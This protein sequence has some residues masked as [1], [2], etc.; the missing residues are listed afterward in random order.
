LASSNEQLA[1]TPP[2][3]PF[4]P[5]SSP[6]ENMD[7]SRSDSPILTENTLSR[8]VELEAKLASQEAKNTQVLDALNTMLRLLTAMTLTQP[9]TLPSTWL[10]VS[11]AT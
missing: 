10:L 5:I 9:T 3:F 6:F 1:V 2:E 8:L 7:L 11:S 4:L